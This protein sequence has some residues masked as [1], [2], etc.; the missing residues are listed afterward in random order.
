MDNLSLGYGGTKKEMERLISDA[1]KYAKTIGETS[2]LSIDSFADIVKAIELVQK[3]Q[4]I[5]ETT[6]KEAATTIQ[7]SLN[8]TKAAWENLLVGIADDSADFDTLINNLVESATAAGEN[9]IPRV[10][11]IIGGIGKAIEKL[12]PVIIERVPALI[13]NVAPGLVSAVSSTAK[14]AFN[15]L[16]DYLPDVFSFGTEVLINIVNGIISA[17]PQIGQ[18][19]VDIIWTLATG[20]G[21]ALPELLPAAVQ[22]IVEFAKTLTN[23]DNISTLVG[24]A[25]SL[26]LNLADGLINALPA[27]I[28]AA[29]AIIQNLIDALTQNIPYI[30]DVAIDVILTLAEGL[31]TNLPAL[32]KAVVQIGTAILTGLWDLAE[33]LL[34]WQGELFVNIL[35]T[36]GSWFSKI[37]SKIGI[38]ISDVWNKIKSFMSNLPE[39]IGFAL[40]FVIAKIVQFGVKAFNWVKTTIP[41][42]IASGVAFVAQLPGKIWNFLV[43]T[44]SKIVSFGAQMKQKSIQ[45]AVDFTVSLVNGLKDLPSKMAEIGSNIVKGIWNGIKNVKDWILKKIKGFGKGVLDGIKKAFGIAS[46][47]KFTAEDGKFLVKGLAKGILDNATDAEKAAA[48]LS[49][50]VLK[51]FNSDGLAMAVSDLP[52]LNTDISTSL[53]ATGAATNEESNTDRLLMMILETLTQLDDGMK[54]KI[55]SAV[56][57]MGFNWNDREVGRFVKTYA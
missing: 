11:K 20:I 4:G 44:I 47:S 38:F 35:S 25:T 2:N 22:A 53:T 56:D 51:A 45:A 28:E 43:Q 8:M 13:A 46:P 31:I 16:L 15:T 23:P 5:Y 37:F 1:N 39:N 14:T 17:L 18:A 42:I 3:K 6:S 52:D 7:G 30:L 9:L 27:L 26:I 10:E 24:A 19:A 40:G 21:T 33:T 55:K 32:L 34:S 54:E 29:P 36:I 50:G 57:G 41:Q 48:K 49:D 12:L